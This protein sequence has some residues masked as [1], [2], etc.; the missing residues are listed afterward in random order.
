MR[1]HTKILVADDDDD[2]REVIALVLEPFGFDTVGACDGVEALAVLRANPDVRLILLDLMMPRLN[3]AEMM[4]S[5]K[6]DVVLGCIPV[7][8]LSGDNTVSDAA[9]AIGAVSYLR[10]PVD[11]DR[12]LDTINRSLRA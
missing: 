7:V 10:K 5:L 11:L 1:E 2:I 9:P 6:E 3:G 12:L 8:I 4:K